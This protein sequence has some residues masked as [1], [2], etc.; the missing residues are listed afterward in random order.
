MRWNATLH[1]E[2]EVEREK[3]ISNNIVVVK[4]LQLKL[5]HFQQFKRLENTNDTNL[6]KKKFITFIF[7]LSFLTD[8]HT[9]TEE[10]SIPS[11]FSNR[12]Q[13]LIVS[14]GYFAKCP[15]KNQQIDSSTW[16]QILKEAACISH[17]TNN[18]GESMTPTILSLDK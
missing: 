1:S 8:D 15:N 11:L 2:E 5:C 7:K 16:F 14:L 4:W 6:W 9:P 13:I 18:L 10:E 12:Q 17:S 3:S